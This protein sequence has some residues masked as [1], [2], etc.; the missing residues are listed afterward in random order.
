MTKGRPC[1][2][3]PIRRIG[4]QAFCIVEVFVPG[5][6]AIDRLPQQMARP[7]CIFIPQRESLGRSAMI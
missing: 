3:H 4:S 5:E 6:P 7:N 1:R 2:D